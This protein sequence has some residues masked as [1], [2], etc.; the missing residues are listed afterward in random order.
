MQ[1]E[2]VLLGREPADGAVDASSLATLIRSL[3][4]A[5][6]NTTA[7][8][9]W[10][11]TGAERLHRRYILRCRD[12]LEFIKR[13]LQHKQQSKRHDDE[14]FESDGD[15][16]SASTRSLGS[17]ADDTISNSSSCCFVD[18]HVFKCNPTATTPNGRPTSSTRLISS[19]TSSCVSS[20]ATDSA[21]SSGASDTEDTSVPSTPSPTAVGTTSVSALVKSLS[22]F[23]QRNAG[24]MISKPLPPPPPPLPPAMA[25]KDVHE[26]L[27]ETYAINEI[28]FCHTDPSFQRIVVW[29]VRKKRSQRL[30]PSGT[31]TSSGLEAIVF[32][33]SSEENMKKLCQSFHETSRRVKLEQYRHPHR[34]KDTS[35]APNRTR[36]SNTSSN[37]TLTPESIIKALK[38]A[39]Q[40][41]PTLPA[42]MKPANTPIHLPTTRI[43]SNGSG[44]GSEAEVLSTV[45]GTRFNLVQRTDG[46]G[47]TH[48]EVSRGL[49]MENPV[50]NL[51][52]LNDDQSLGGP[53][54]II[55]ISTPDVGNLLAANTNTGNKS[56]FCKEIEGVIRSDV[57][58]G[59]TR[60]E[61][62]QRQRQPAI[63]VV[64]SSNG[65]DNSSGEL[66]KVWSPPQSTNLPQ[67]S[68]E[69]GE[70]I[71]H[72]SDPPQRPERKRYMRRN[73]APAPQ[74]PSL[75]SQVTK[76]LQQPE[77]VNNKKLPLT[78]IQSD[79]NTTVMPQKRVSNTNQQM[80]V[81][82]QFIRV[83][84]DQKPQPTMVVP[85][86]QQGT[87]IY[88]NNVSTGNLVA[89]SPAPP[90]WGIHVTA[91][92]KSSSNKNHVKRKNAEDSVI[93]SSTTP[94][95]HSQQQKQEP[96]GQ[97]HYRKNRSRSRNAANGN[98]RSKSP[99]ARRPMAY[100]YIDTVPASNTGNSLSNRFFGLSQKL[101]EIGGAVVNPS[102]SSLLY[103]E[104]TRRRNSIG[105]LPAR[106]EYL[107][108]GCAGG[109][110]GKNGGNLK[111]VIKKNRRIGECSEPKKVTFSAYATVQVVD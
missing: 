61:T 68:I 28:A 82:G 49:P 56:R 40:K 111:S 9:G 21:N 53:S 79:T 110:E 98:H 91:A 27:K 14:G 17:S 16:D 73:K 70:H 47:V 90:S 58:V 23:Q 24:P 33:C 78:L 65:D 100:R 104:T 80:V 26:E 76:G 4:P 10:T 54:S 66:R 86:I 35:P 83:S 42:I 12:G 96:Q 48:I 7:S 92:N 32:E 50:E 103:S 36:S 3:L 62:M 87:W 25:S 11:N 105:E 60:K 64:H 72:S 109:T 29:V 44:P 89:Y 67:A 31:D 59:G 57:D 39:S 45:A 107:G 101:R 77:S 97:Q 55:S 15:D 71:S 94:Q 99:P 108:E 13:P 5:T 18:D 20:V 43:S 88:G 2:A 95:Y 19:S 81:K 84:V 63:L 85:V 52:A 69:D 8:S 46:D 37:P 74:P 22:L 1:C 106:L 6:R 75:S 41:S 30:S 93:N 38:E 51:I 102:S 34:R